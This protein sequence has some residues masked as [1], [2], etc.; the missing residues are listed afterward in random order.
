MSTLQ[1]FRFSVVACT[2]TLLVR[3]ELAAATKKPKPNAMKCIALHGDG[4]INAPAEALLVSRSVD[5]YVTIF[6]TLSAHRVAHAYRAHCA[7]VRYGYI[8]T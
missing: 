6:D 3:E 4:I 2:R 5:R 7:T 8:C 1:I